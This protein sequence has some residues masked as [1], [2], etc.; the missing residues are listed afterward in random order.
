MSTPEFNLRYT[1]DEARVLKD[2]LVKLTGEWLGITMTEDDELPQCWDPFNKTEHTDI[3]VVLFGLYLRAI[4]NSSGLSYA[5][6]RRG[7]TVVYVDGWVGG[8]IG[9]REVPQEFKDLTISLFLDAWAAQNNDSVANLCTLSDK[10][11]ILVKRKAGI[12]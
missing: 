4:W 9:K 12:C 1:L 8:V 5:V 6:Y 10:D 7:S 11:V 2:S 3:L